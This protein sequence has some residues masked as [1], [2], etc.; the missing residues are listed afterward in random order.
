MELR[1][2]R[3]A[4]KETYTIGREEWRK[5]SISPFYEVSNMGRARSLDRT[6]VRSDGVVVRYKGKILKPNIGTNGYKYINCAV[7]GKHI[8]VYLHKEIARVFIGDPNGLDVDHINSVKTDNRI[9]NLRYLSHFENSS[10]ANKGRHRDH[11]L[12]KNTRAK[13]VVGCLNGKEYERFD[14][15]KKITIK[16]GVNYSTL[17]RKLQTGGIVI[18]GI[19]YSY[20]T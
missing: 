14:C 6:I 7:D 11:S 15:A 10:R 16:Y 4:K 17:R 3:I 8:T 1:L 9:E 12:E 19:N 13:T 5:T 2:K 18:N 20:G